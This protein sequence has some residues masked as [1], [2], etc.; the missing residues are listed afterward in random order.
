MIEL[1]KF[2]DRNNTNSI[3]YVDNSYNSVIKVAEKDIIL[4]DYYISKLLNGKIKNNKY[5]PG[6]ID[7]TNIGIFKTDNTIYKYINPYSISMPYYI[8]R[9]FRVVDWFKNL[10]G[11]KSCLKQ[12]ILSIYMAYVKFGFNIIVTI[13]NT[14]IKDT[15][16]KYIN[17]DGMYIETNGLEVVI[18]DFEYSYF[19]TSKSIIKNIRHFFFNIDYYMYIEPNNIDDINNIL[20]INDNTLKNI[21]KL[22]ILIDSIVEIKETLMGSLI[23]NSNNI[24]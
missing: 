9:S 3:K 2:S 15:S 16:N 17:Y 4:Y 11:F 6:F 18:M 8:Y 19:R 13:N 5:V 23:K 10:N 7:Y 20:Q 22:L 12:V 24:V 21:D 1:Y 14:I